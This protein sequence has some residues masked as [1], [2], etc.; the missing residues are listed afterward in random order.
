[1][2]VILKYSLGGLLAANGVF[3]LFA[4]LTWYHA[5]PGVTE[6][7]SFNPHFV[8]DIGAAY[9]AAGVGLAWFAARRKARTAAQ[10]AALF[11]GVH[12]LIHLADALSGRETWGGLARDFPGVFLPAVL[13]VWLAWRRPSKA[14][15]SGVTS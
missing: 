8:R 10:V 7:G 6:T 3:M 14:V 5:V 1:M 4:P 11:L 13:A 9:L 2:R 15:T 12:A